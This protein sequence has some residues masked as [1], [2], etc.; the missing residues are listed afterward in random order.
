MGIRLGY[1]QSL[2]RMR[3]AGVSIPYDYTV[4][5][6]PIEWSD[7]RD[8]G[9][10]GAG[11][12][13]DIA[14]ASNGKVA[15]AGGQRG[16]TGS[17]SVNLYENTGGTNGGTLLSAD[18]YIYSAAG[19]LQDVSEIG[20]TANYS[21]AYTLAMAPDGASVYIA[22][23]AGDLHYTYTATGVPF[24]ATFA[25][26]SNPNGFYGDQDGFIS[27]FSLVDGTL[28]ASTYLG[29]ADGDLVR[30]IDIGADGTIHCAMSRYG[31]G[32]PVISNLLVRMA[33]DL[34]SK[35]A[36]WDP[37]NST[38]TAGGTP[39]VVV[40]GNYAYYQVSTAVAMG[41]GATSGAYDETFGAGRVNQYV[42]KLL[43]G[44]SRYT[45]VAATYFKDA[46]ADLAGET[47][48]ISV[49]PNGD[50]LISFGA[51]SGSSLPV[52]AD[53]YKSA[54]HGGTGNS[55]GVAIFDNN[56]T[57]LKYCSYFDGNVTNEVTAVDGTYAHSDGRFAIVGHT[58]QTGMPVTDGSAGSAGVDY[59]WY[60]VFAPTIAGS[61]TLE[62]CGY[63]RA[64]EA[65][66]GIFDPTTGDLLVGGIEADAGSG[67]SS[68][69]LDR[70]VRLPVEAH[71]NKAAGADVYLETPAALTTTLPA[72]TGSVGTFAA[73]V[74]KPDDGLNDNMFVMTGDVETSIRATGGNVV[75]ASF[76][77]GAN[78]ASSAGAFQ[79]DRWFTFLVTFDFDAGLAFVYIDGAEV[80]EYTGLAGSQTI[81]TGALS[82]LKGTLFGIECAWLRCWNVYS[83]DG[84]IPSETPLIDEG[85]D[86]DDVNASPYIGGADSYT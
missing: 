13:R 16:Y 57:T 14:V 45:L 3:S 73:S 17:P 33:A 75:R 40:V 72:F 1:G 20:A 86:P 38:N 79:N 25:G 64:G 47:H 53:A 41:V 81:G 70:Y 58:N 27:Q 68:N 62:A 18:L 10:S 31:S 32:T 19:V 35:I 11:Q 24:Q 15:A 8:N 74:R 22:G 80:L 85:P 7:I 83:A 2:S 37:L 4:Y 66:R 28:I 77:G 71:F 9:A 5:E 54:P 46:T 23:R 43:I 76:K 69:Y 59:G 55:T 50:V 61:Y 44:P 30:G 67:A 42:A 65:R 6:Y 39:S 48:A 78:Q 21:R 12:F 36:T 63:V 29:Y 82:M 51:T 56:L 26:D 34:K 49:L 60:A 84:S 52:T